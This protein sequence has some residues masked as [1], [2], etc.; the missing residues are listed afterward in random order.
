MKIQKIDENNKCVAV[1]DNI[2][3]AA[4]SIDANR[5]TWQIAMAIAYAINTN[6]RAYKFKW[7]KVEF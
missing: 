5:E 1:Y 6:T 3:A 7:K 2:T 4:K